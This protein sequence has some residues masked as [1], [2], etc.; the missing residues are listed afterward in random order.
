MLAISNP[1]VPTK[2]QLELDIDHTKSNF[3]GKLSVQLRKT[4]AGSFQEFQLHSKELVILQAT[5]G[6]KPL[7][8]AYDRPQQLVNFKSDAPIDTQDLTLELSYIGKINGIKTY[9][10]PTRGIF[11]TNFMNQQTGSSDSFAIATHG[12]P[13]FARMIL[14]CIDE[15]NHKAHFQL[16]IKTN[17]RFKVMSNTL[18][19][20]KMDLPETNEQLISF[21]E[22]PLMN[23]SLFGFALGDFEFIQSLVKLPQGDVPIR[24]FSPQQI[25]DTTFALDTIIETLPHLQKFFGC[26]YPL[27]KLDFVLLPFLSDM[28]MENFGLV[29]VQ[30][31]HLLIPPHALNNRTTR[32]QVRQLVVHELV[33][34]WMG[35]YISFDSWEHLWFNEA[36]ATWCACHILEKIDNDEYWISDEYLQQLENVIVQDSKFSTPSILESSR[37]SRNVTQTSDVFDPHAYT[38]GISLLRSLCCCI[39]DEK[40]ANSWSKVFAN[41][42]LFHEH[43]IKPLDLWSF[44]GQELKSANIP[45]YVSSWTRLPGSPLLT[46]TKEDGVTKLEQHRLILT[47]EHDFEDVPYHIPLFIRLPDGTIDKEQMLLTDRSTSISYPTTMFNADSQGPY[48]VSYESACCYEEINAA[49]S[50]GTLSATDLY[51]I[52]QDLSFFIGDVKYQKEIHITGVVTLLEHIASEKVNLK[53]NPQYY[54]GLSIGLEILQTIERSIITYKGFSSTNSR[55]TIIKPLFK[56][57][58]WPED[59]SKSS[60]SPYELEVMSQ[61]LFASKD[62]QEVFDLS[63]RYFKKILQGPNQSIPLEIVGSVFSVVSR[64]TT[65]VKEWKKLLELVKSCEGI[66]P[67]VKGCDSPVVL[68]NYA[69]ENLGFSLHVELIKKVLNFVTTNIDS[70]SV[71][72]ALF[73]LNYNA[74]EKVGKETVRDL[75]WNW[76]SLHYDQW[77]GKSLREGSE[78][79]ERMK[80]SLTN[81]S[82]VVFQMFVDTPE[83]IDT[84]AVMKQSKFGK[85]IGTQDVWKMVKDGEASRMK[86]YQG[87][88]G[89]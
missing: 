19:S 67:H 69:I 79:S 12:Q 28:A 57:L 52:F 4:N 77:A 71:E 34:Q 5:V 54:H 63:K 2:Y 38:K 23:A 70:T 36:F 68:Q 18:P 81:I 21:N 16:S 22:T 10:E 9:H 82:M 62:E 51:R 49:L 73:G 80:K 15:P 39:G 48:R 46:V 53:K 30:M 59:F 35:N 65:T 72:L 6:G 3:K 33:H 27:D 75:V 40:F 78:S 60:L 13:T 76:F 66:T 20:R 74:H 64:L 42:S 11:K 29:T 43:S 87:I 25:T 24:I 26:N 89:F 86:I 47:E 14:P 41:K 31:S 61:L 55:E 17:E 83:K 44:I 45:N 7:S 32:Q 84:F 85:V 37:K 1:V 8:I 58:S 56:K 88:L 50:Q